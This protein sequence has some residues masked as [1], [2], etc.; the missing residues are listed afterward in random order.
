M[1][2]YQELRREADGLWQASFNHPFVR[3]IADG[4]LPLESFRYYVIQ[5]AHYLACFARAKALAAAKAPDAEA[6]TLF[7]AHVQNTYRAEAALHEQ[8][9]KALGVTADEKDS[10]PQA[11]T[12]YA[13]TSHLL[14][15]AH[16]GSA[17][18]I[19]AAVLPCYGLYREIGERLRGAEPPVEL[20]RK[21]I[22]AYGSQWFDQAVR[23]MIACCD[24]LAQRCSDAEL[25]RLRRH[26]LISS[27]Y[28][29][30]FWEMA[31]RREAWPQSADR[32]V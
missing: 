11:P 28:E 4:S 19:A 30:Q 31:Y 8:F 16:E 12:A 25:D 5:D 27:Y 13:Y 18:E 9:L 23:E 10:T 14:R 1:G 32:P 24:R 20:Y 26:F 29:W 7:A 22:E 21:W 3:G 17:A 6:A 15:V 2:I